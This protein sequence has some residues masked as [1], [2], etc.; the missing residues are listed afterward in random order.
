MNY[1]YSKCTHLHTFMCVFLFFPS[2]GN[3]DRQYSPDSGGR[4]RKRQRRQRRHPRGKQPGVPILRIGG[5]VSL[6]D[7][8]PT[9]R[10]VFLRITTQI[11][12]FRLYCATA[13]AS[14]RHKA[15]K[16]NAGFRVWILF[17]L[18]MCSFSLLFLDW[19]DG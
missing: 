17:F 9:F 3:R 6:T 2:P 11:I 5:V 15:I 19:Y 4:H 12:E 10:F 16:N 8:S 7:I 13:Y 18:V 1:Y 14:L